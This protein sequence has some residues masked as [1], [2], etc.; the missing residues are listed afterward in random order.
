MSSL[1][2]SL[3][4]SLRTLI[5]QVQAAATSRAPLQIRGAGSKD[6][7]G[8][9][10]HGGLMDMRPHAGITQYDPTELVITARAG[11]PMADL[12][13][14]LARA[15]QYLPFDPPCFGP[16][17]TV[18]GM[19]AA[20][21]AGPARAS[22]GGVRDYVL[23]ATLLNGKGELLT[24]GGQV[25]KN[26]AGYDV[27]RLLVGSLGV[28]GAICEVSLKVLPMP[29]ASTT[30]RVEMTQIQALRVFNQW[31]SQPAPLHAGV[32]WDDTLAVWLRGAAA[33]VEATAQRLVQEVRA[34]VVDPDFAASFWS[35]LRDHRDEFFQQAYAAVQTGATLWRV[36]VPQV[37]APLLVSGEQLIEWGGAQRWICT[38]APAAQLRQAARE[39][40]GHATLFHGQ[41]KSPGVFEPL[42]APLDRIHRQLK[43][44]FDPSGIFNRGRLYPDL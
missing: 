38:T 15:G 28:L 18:G 16:Q 12:N 5:D 3:P 30:L 8:G 7:Y 19:V 27:S 26:V 25:M 2:P 21:L 33:A 22:V 11:T 31:S 14:A 17:S 29:V 32:W 24:F 9:H 39:A 1:P 10:C 44:A 41:D 20:G 13:D 4:I 34:D 6:F 23:G 35:G 43:L 37:A 40:G 36:S 42:G